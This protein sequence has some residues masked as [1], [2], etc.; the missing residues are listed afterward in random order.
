MYGC[1][2]VTV[3]CSNTVGSST[4]GT[5]CSKKTTFCSAAFVSDSLKKQKTGNIQPIYLRTLYTQKNLIKPTRNQIVFT[6]F[7]L[8]WN[9]TDVR[10]VPNGSYSKRKIVNKI[11]L[12]FDL[13]RFWTKFSVRT[14]FR[15]LKKMPFF[16][17]RSF[18]HNNFAIFYQHIIDKIR[19]FSNLI[20]MVKNS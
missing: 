16:S 12:Q 2:T 6:L 3:F 20:T 19:Y 4:L 1:H 15:T 8:I 7:W 18:Q 11:W 17:E 10:L 9:Q 14:H 5:F 13:I